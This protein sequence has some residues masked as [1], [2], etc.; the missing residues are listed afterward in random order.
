MEALTSGEIDSG[1]CQDAPVEHQ[2]SSAAT[3]QAR[4]PLQRTLGESDLVGG[5]QE[6]IVDR[7]AQLN[8]LALA[9]DAAQP[10]RR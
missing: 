1:H 5:V 8:L 3:E 9:P 10:S 2:Q 6:Q 4:R 7:V